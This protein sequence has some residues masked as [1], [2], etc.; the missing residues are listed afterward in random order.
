M[1][2]ITV[3]VDMGEFETYELLDEL[4]KR[5]KRGVK[6]LSH[7]RRKEIKDSVDE[8]N[9][10]LSGIVGFEVKTLEDRMK[11]EH[12]SKVFHKYHS[13]FIEKVLPE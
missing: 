5:I 9:N 2:Y 10:Q 7:E 3:D 1:S 13:S 11:Y 8:L 4:K 6:N 12:I